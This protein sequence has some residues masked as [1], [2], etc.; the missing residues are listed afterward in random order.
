MSTFVTSNPNYIG[1]SNPLDPLSYVSDFP[2]TSAV[3]QPR[4]GGFTPTTLG[5]TEKTYNSI[6]QSDINAI[7]LWAA[8]N[9]YSYTVSEQFGTTPSSQVFSIT[10][11][12]PYDEITDTDNKVNERVQWEITENVVNRD[13]FDA[14]IFT[15]NSFGQ[16]ITTQRYTV[17]PL[18][19]T[20]IREALKY[21]P[22]GNINFENVNGASTLTQTQ[23]QQLAPLKP[24]AYQFFYL[25]KSGVTSIKAATIHVRRTAVYSINDPNAYDADPYYNLILSTDPVRLATSINPI[26]SQYDLI[27]YFK[28]DNVTAKQLLPSYSICKSL[29]NPPWNDPYTSFAR[30]GYLVHVPI[31]EFITPTKV[32]ITQLFEWDEWLDTIYPCYS[33]VTDFPLISPTPYP[34]NYKGLSTS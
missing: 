27:R 18:V 8:N 13:L 28:P 11:T 34:P 30:A 24:I 33:P 23:V 21:N 6:K 17:P 25:M 3:L 19:R 4:K 5:T 14:G 10:V 1:K 32:K 12:L 9:N 7:A 20:A 16:L 26:I 31:R 2:Q 22:Y 29:A 15:T